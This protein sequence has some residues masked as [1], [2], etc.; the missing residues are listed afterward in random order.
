MPTTSEQLLPFENRCANS[1]DVN[2]L[3]QLNLDRQ[4][5][6]EISRVAVAKGVRRRKGE[7]ASRFGDVLDFPEIDSRTGSL[8]IV[9]VF[10]AATALA[11]NSG[12]SHLFM[13]LEPFVVKILD[14]HN[15]AFQQVGAENNYQGI[16][17]PYLTTTNAI[18]DTLDADTLDLYNWLKEQI[19]NSGQNRTEA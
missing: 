5:I 9:A 15:I 19:F 4:K 6:A 16:R 11:E 8:P 14:K 7:V 18:L 17:A 2:L 13:L 1:L 3:S 10:L 12:R